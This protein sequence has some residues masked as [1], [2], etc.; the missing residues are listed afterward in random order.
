M[1]KM[2]IPFLSVILGVFSGVTVAFI[3]IVLRFNYMAYKREK[4]ILV[5]LIDE[6]E[7]NRKRG[8]RIL[9]NISKNEKGKY[10]LT[11]SNEVFIETLREGI[12]TKLSRGLRKKLIEAYT[13]INHINEFPGHITT[14]N[15]PEKFKKDV[16]YLIGEEKDNEKIKK[17]MEPMPKVEK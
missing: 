5:S 11:F 17:Q 16:K 9:R 6:L 8:K 7:I 12:Y 2:E 4:R 14:V 15:R 10:V 3:S 13:Y 1:M